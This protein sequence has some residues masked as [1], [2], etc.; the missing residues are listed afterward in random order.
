MPEIIIIIPSRYGSTRL[1]GKPL[2]K[3]AGKPMI[4]HVY[5]QSQKAV[6]ISDVIVATDD[7]RIFDTIIGFGGNARMTSGKHRSGTDRIA[8]V[9]KRLKA[10]I[11]VNVQG[12][13]PLVKPRMIEELVSPI[14]NEDVVMSTLKCKIK[15]KEDIENPNIVKVVT[16][17]EDNALYFSRSIIPHSIGYKNIY[18]H[19]GLYAYKKDFLIKFSQMSPSNLEK[20]ESLEQLRVL[21]NG[22]KIKVVETQ[23]QSQGVDTLDDVRRVTSLIEGRY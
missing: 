2:I 9:A 23:N 16:D 18:K 22:W 15:N 21:E 1:K 20:I 8:E 5:E 14:I 6:G 7:K 10:E 4:Q 19:I 17:L 13:E 11:I 3:I 12:D